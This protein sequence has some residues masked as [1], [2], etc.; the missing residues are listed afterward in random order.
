LLPL[1]TEEFTPAAAGLQ[2]GD[3]QILQGSGGSGEESRFFALIEPTRPGD[4]APLF[5]ARQRS[6]R[7]ELAPHR[8]V[9]QRAQIRQIPVACVERSIPPEVFD[10]FRGDRR[11]VEARERLPSQEVGYRYAGFRLFQ[12]PDD[13]ALGELRFTHDHS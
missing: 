11:R 10:D 2:R 8:P 1:E 13:L 4:L 9:V 7:Y 3:N 6:R 12:N 5:D